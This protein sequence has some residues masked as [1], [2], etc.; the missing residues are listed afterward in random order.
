MT[1]LCVIGTEASA[2]FQNVLILAQVVSLLI[3]AGG[4]AVPGGHR[5]QP[6]GVAHPVDQLAEPVRRGRR[7]AHR[8]AC[9]SGVFTYWGWESAVNLTEETTNSESTPGKAAIVS[10]VVLLVTYLAVAYAV[11]AFAGTTF[12]ADNAGEEE[13]IFALLGEQVLGGWDWVLLL[14]VS[15]SA[16]ASTQTTIIPASR[17]G[18]SMA[19]RAALPRRLAHIHPRFRTP[20][21]STWTVAGD[22]HRL[23][24]RDQHHQRERA[25]RLD[26]RAVAADRLLLL[27]DRHRLRRLLPQAAAAQR[28]EPAADRGRPGHRLDPADLAAD[29]LHLRPE[30]PGGLVQ[31]GRLVRLRPAAGDRRRDLPG[32]RRCS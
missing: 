3:F 4:G 6:A 29:P 30:R 10:T 19:R 26:H 2:R 11:V 7:G 28:V 24:R 12:L 18:L 22:R 25:V 17:T 27:A 20:D 9:C 15:T 14:A 31:R 13:S 1:A 5:R 16:L 23:V 32:R 8:R 21:V